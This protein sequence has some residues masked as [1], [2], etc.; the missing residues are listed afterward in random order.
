MSDRNQTVEQLRIR[1]EHPE[2]ATVEA[3]VLD[4]AR[5]TLL[6]LARGEQPQ[7]VLGGLMLLGHWSAPSALEDEPRSIPEIAAI[8]MVDA[9]DGLNHRG[10]TTRDVLADLIAVGWVEQVDAGPDSVEALLSR[11]RP[12]ET[13]K[14]TV[15]TAVI[16][17]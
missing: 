14:L 4:E 16:E 12:L 13:Y 3:R 8:G 11:G 2:F 5:L 10:D 15:P 17:A 9:G 7:T 1:N 6:A